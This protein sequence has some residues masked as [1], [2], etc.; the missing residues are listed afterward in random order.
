MRLWLPLIA[1][2]IFAP[3]ALGYT[4]FSTRS[5]AVICARVNGHVNC[6]DT[7]SIGSYVAWSKSVENIAIARDMSQ[8]GS[9]QG[10]VAETEA[11]SQ[12]PLTSTFLDSS[13]QAGIANRIHQFIFVQTDQTQLSFNLGLSLIN[14]GLGG[15]LTLVLLV[16]AALSALRI[17]QRGRATQPAVP[18]R[19]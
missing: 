12:V 9:N 8:S 6:T 18:R 16:L 3:L 4:A 7:E 19:Q 10:V 5:A 17:V 13:Q 15:T 1:A 14:L 2:L 11:G